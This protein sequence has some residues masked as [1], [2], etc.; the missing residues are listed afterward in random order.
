LFHSKGI[1]FTWYLITC[2]NFSLDTMIGRHCSPFNSHYFTKSHARKMTM[3]IYTFI[4]S[5]AS[6]CLISYF[7]IFF[8]LFL[9]VL[10]VWYGHGMYRFSIIHQRVYIKLLP[11][12]KMIFNLMLTKIEC[13]FLEQCL[14]MGICFGDI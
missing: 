4:L 1:S 6:H 11:Y 5:Y 7:D 10:V 2:S 13:F 12:I 3:K 8:L 9:H 14:Q